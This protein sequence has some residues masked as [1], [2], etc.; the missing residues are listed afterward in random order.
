MAEFKATAA[1]KVLLV[2]ALHAFE[3][4]L[5]R[6]GKRDVAMPAVAKAFE[7]EAVSVRELRSRIE[8]V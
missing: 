4:S 3:A 1:D 2:R 6:A 8:A 7:A 5:V